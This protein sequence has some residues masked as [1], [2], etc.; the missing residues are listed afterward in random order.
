MDTFKSCKRRWYLHYFLGL[1][2]RTE[3]RAVPRDTGTLVHAALDVFYK[4]GGTTNIE[5][6]RDAVSEFV[7]RQRIEDQSTVIDSEV[8]K[9]QQTYEFA[10]IA[11]DGY[12]AWL[13]ATGADDPYD[14]Q[15]SEVKLTAPGPVDGTTLL[16]ILDLAGTHRASG[17]LFVMDTKTITSIDTTIKTL[18]LNEQAPMYATLSTINDGN[19]DRHFRVVW[20]LIRRCK[21]TKKAKPPFY[22]R[23][24]LA[25]N[26]ATLDQ[27]WRQLH[28]QVKDILQAEQRLNAGQAHVEVCYPAPTPDC[29]WKCPYIMICGTM[30]D[31]RNDITWM[32]N[33]Y[34]STAAEREAVGLLQEAENASLWD[35]GNDS[36]VESA[37]PES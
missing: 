6:A 17:D 5:Q 21:Q 16:G 27:F 13:L 12:V 15:E 3:R 26:T 10:N 31:P 24:E 35:L 33:E 32:L 4:R 2:R 30:N 14:F 36:V 25:L 20:N 19:P 37:T 8:D 23:Y 28:G 34:Y 9:L 29:S 11:I 1:R 7:Q 18:N 22:A